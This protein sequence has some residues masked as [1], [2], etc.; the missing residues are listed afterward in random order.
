VTIRLVER[1]IRLVLLDIEGTTTPIT[2]VYDVLFPYARRHLRAYVQRQV[3]AGDSEVRRAIDLLRAEHDAEG[4]PGKWSDETPEATSDSGASYAELLMGRDSK[5]PGLKLLQGLVWQDGYSS[6]ELKG[7]VFED[8]PRALAA[9]RDAGIAAAIYSSGSVLAQQ[10]LFGSTP[11]GDLRP[12]LC[13]YFDTAVGGKRSAES[14]G[15]ISRAVDLSPPSILFVSDIS[16]ELDAAAAAGLVTTLCVRPGN[17][18]QSVSDDIP[19]IRSFDEIV[20]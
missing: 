5:S 10:L 14:Y 20:A 1:G 12:A 2:F 3:A 6:G 15:S 4:R 19:R 17:P 9:W 7:A 18:D 8:V 11:Y 16:E 13:G